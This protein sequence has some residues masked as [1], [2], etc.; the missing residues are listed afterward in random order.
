MCAPRGLAFWGH[1]SMK[2]CR[3]PYAPVSE[4]PMLLPAPVSV[5]D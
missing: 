1:W 4:R 5:A 3:A 2:G